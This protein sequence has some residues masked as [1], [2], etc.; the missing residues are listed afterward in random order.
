MIA[1]LTRVEILLGAALEKIKP[2]IIRIVR[3]V[4]I[5][6][7]LTA[8]DP[9]H[10]PREIGLAILGYFQKSL[11]FQSRRAFLVSG[12]EEIEGKEVVVIALRLGHGREN[13][14]FAAKIGACGLDFLL[15]ST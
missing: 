2:S 3:I 14:Q 13:F 12:G 9:F 5:V 8:D 11:L 1:Q 15:G 4:S 7:M 10:A 6:P